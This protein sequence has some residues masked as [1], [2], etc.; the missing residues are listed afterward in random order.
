[1]GETAMT[2]IHVAAAPEYN[3]TGQDYTDRRHFRYTGPIIDI[4]AHVMITRPGDPPTGPPLGTGPGASL[5]QAETMLDVAAEFG[6]M[7]TVTM[8]PPDDVIPLRERFGDRLA[9]NAMIMKRTADESDDQ[10][11]R[12]L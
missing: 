1:M 7:Q 5:A 11:Y 3:V 12:T 4:H 8:C 9:F 6:I 10:A 2:A